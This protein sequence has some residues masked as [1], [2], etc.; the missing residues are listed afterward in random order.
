MLTTPTTRQF[1]LTEKQVWL[2]ITVTVILLQF[3]ALFVPILEPDGA[4]YAGIAKTMVLKHDYWNLYADGHDWLDKPHF[5]FWMAAISFNLFGIHT[6]SYKLP[7]I[8]FLLTGAWYTYRFALDLYDEKVAR[9]AVCI[10]LTAEHLVISNNDVRAE[11]YLTGLIIAGVYHFYKRQMLPG[12]LFTACAIMT[13]G[14]FALVPIGAAIGGH[15]LFTRDWK[16][17]L[18][19]RWLIALMLTA[20]FIT[21]EL[22][23]LYQQFD[24]HPEK[25]VF[26]TTG[27][28][29]L[30]FFFWDSQFGRFMNTG[31]IKGAGDPFF[32][33]HTLL[34]AFLPWSVMLYAAVI[35]F[36]KKW[37]QQKEYY[38]I[39]AAMATFALF[40]LSK[41]QLP[42]YLN[43]IFPFFAILTAQYILSLQTEKGLKFFRI[44]QYTII[45]LIAVAGVV[46]D[47]LYKPAMHYTWL[48]LAGALILLY[49]LLHYWLD[50]ST[51]QAIFYRTVS[52]SIL[53]NL[54]LNTILYP[55]MMQYQSGSTAGA[56]ANN[57]LPGR[58]IGMYAA[59]SYAFDFYMKA[60]VARY[61]TATFASPVL[62]FTTPEAVTGLQQQ[63]HICT[64]IKSFPHFYVSKLDLPFVRKA[65][66]AGALGERVI[67]EVK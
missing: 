52:I 8:L 56:Y 45:I 6:W 29:G 53:L 13:K 48:L 64:V 57:S 25:L 17:L 30:R 36:I 61:D 11:P 26:G 63:G 4:L 43:I 42:H 50:K 2:L 67:V 7:A 59:N 20:L 28:S 10:L 62:L 31:P 22:Y 41:F 32:F 9:W 19:I 47:L 1:I 27:V 23:A 49:V 15:L 40:S 16:A 37:K 24:L 55:D 18:H 66:R 38:C 39:C 12:A 58:T 44:T 51:R 34:W 3:S 35:I 14:M 65:T 33:F 46:I 21:P 5:P 60:P 54:Y